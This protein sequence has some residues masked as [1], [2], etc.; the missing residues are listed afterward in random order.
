MVHG[1]LRRFTLAPYYTEHDNWGHL[2]DHCDVTA[3]GRCHQS[4]DARR[5]KTI[6]GD[7]SNSDGGALKS[8]KDDQHMGSGQ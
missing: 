2:S 8:D 6:I 7:S 3:P 1:P 4:K 5:D